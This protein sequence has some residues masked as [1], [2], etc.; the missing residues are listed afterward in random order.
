V[1]RSTALSRATAGRGSLECDE[2]V[3]G[4][5]AIERLARIAAAGGLRGSATA[6]IPA[7][8]VGD[9]DAVQEIPD[10]LAWVPLAGG[11]DGPAGSRRRRRA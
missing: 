2:R 11:R 8:P 7:P 10:E 1:L 3:D 6:A 5:G 9:L 4:G